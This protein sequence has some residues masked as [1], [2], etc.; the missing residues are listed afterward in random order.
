MGRIHHRGHRGAQRGGWVD[1]PRG[2]GDAV[3]GME[4]EPSQPVEVPLDALSAAALRGLVEEFVSRD[5]TDYGRHERTLEEKVAD[6][7]RQLQRGEAAIVYDPGTRSANIV[8][9][10]PGAPAAGQA[11]SAA[12]RRS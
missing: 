1:A 12:R 6:V 5:G 7:L 11:A 8:V 9:R 10:R 3:P 4:D 2:G